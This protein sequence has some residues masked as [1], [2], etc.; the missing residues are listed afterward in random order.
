MHAAPAQGGRILHCD[1]SDALGLDEL[2]QRLDRVVEAR[3][4][5]RRRAR[6]ARVHGQPIAFFPELSRLGIARQDD[7]PG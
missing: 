2:P 6:A 7:R 4:R 1:R 5:G 3:R